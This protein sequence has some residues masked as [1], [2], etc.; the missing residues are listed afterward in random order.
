MTTT[1]VSHRATA[2]VILAR[3]V[4]LILLFAVT[5]PSFAQHHLV[6]GG[7][8]GMGGYVGPVVKFSSVDGMATAFVGGRAGMMIPLDSANNMTIG[9]AMY[10]MMNDIAVGEAAGRAA[11]QYLRMGYGGL[12]LGYVLQPGTLVHF[13]AGTLLG[14]G[15]ADC[16][17][18]AYYDSRV[19]REAFFVAEPGVGLMLNATSFLRLG[20]EASYRFA[21]ATASDEFRGVQLS[22]PAGGI[23][24][25]FG[26]HR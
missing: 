12:E 2:E 25:Q 21:G 9:G 26:R 17:K 6:G 5:G 11:S 20:L 10:G 8:M 18:D 22:G 1:L 24:L 4:W 23:T 16:G 15:W 3:T 14:M 13:S 7:M 19:R